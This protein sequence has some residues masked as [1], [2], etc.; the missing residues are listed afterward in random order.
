MKDKPLL[1]PIQSRPLTGIRFDEPGDVLRLPFDH[2]PHLQQRI[3]DAEERLWQARY[4]DKRPEAIWEAERDLDA[5]KADLFTFRQ[6]HARTFLFGLR[7]ALH[8]H[9]HLTT[10]MLQQ[11]AKG[12]GK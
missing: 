11:A 6:E 8:H 3:M 12:G 5:A 1:I 7:W 2:Q 9:Y 4:R 10:D